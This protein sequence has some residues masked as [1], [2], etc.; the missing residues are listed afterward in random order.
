[1]LSPPASVLLCHDC[2]VT[3]GTQNIHHEGIGGQDAGLQHGK[4]SRIAAGYQRH[5]PVINLDRLLLVA[6]CHIPE[7]HFGQLVA[8][9]LKEPL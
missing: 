6:A 4:D 1:M 7:H 2:C 3:L 8:M 9:L 5:A